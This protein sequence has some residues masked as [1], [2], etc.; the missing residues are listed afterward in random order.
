MFKSSPGGRHDNKP[1]H[2]RCK[3]PPLRLLALVGM[4]SMAS[5]LLAQNNPPVQPGAN[6]PRPFQE[7]G[8]G[9]KTTHGVETP[10][11]FTAEIEA[12]ARK[13]ES[14]NG[15]PIERNFY[16]SIIHAD[17]MREFAAL[18]RY[19]LLILTVVTQ[20]PE[21]LPL[22]RVYIRTADKQIPLLKLA[23]WRRNVEQSLLTYKMY[24][25]D[26]EDGF[27]LLPLSAYLRTAQLQ[28]DF[29]ANRSALPI[30]EFPSRWPEW[31]RTP[32]DPDPPPNALPDLRTLQRLIRRETA[33]FPA[34]DSLPQVAEARKPVPE[35]LPQAGEPKHPPSLKDLFKQ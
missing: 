10:Q 25:S 4:I 31:L 2:V 35:T 28:A 9:L 32:Q 6:P 5:P 21:E 16:F 17:N 26:R 20:K 18:A 11:R 13:R 19:S 3:I 30:I 1:P 22:K 29:A 24:G 27:Y 15:G 12:E 23:S 7:K 8:S 14:S 33:G 34:I